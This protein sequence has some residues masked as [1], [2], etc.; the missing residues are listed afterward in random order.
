MDHS[1]TREIL[2][3]VPVA[4]IVIMYALLAVLV[5]AF[6]FAGRYWSQCIRIGRSESRFDRPL[7][8]AW[9]MLRDAVGQGYVVRETWGWMHYAFYVGFIGLFIGTTNRGHQQ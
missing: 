3:N 4:F 2:W 9:L 1:I 7:L 8:R 5:V 6:I